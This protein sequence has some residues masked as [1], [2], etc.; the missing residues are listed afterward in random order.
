MYLKKGER[1]VRFKGRQKRKVFVKTPDKRLERHAA[2][3]ISWCQPPSG[4]SIFLR[5]IPQ[6]DKMA[7]GI[8]QQ[9]PGVEEKR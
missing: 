7:T 1:R 5:D 3:K 8:G 6:R 9:L 4:R 2:K